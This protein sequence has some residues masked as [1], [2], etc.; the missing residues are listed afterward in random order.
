MTMGTE[1]QFEAVVRLWLKQ[2]PGAVV[3][4]TIQENMETVLSMKER[5][6]DDRI[7]VKCVPKA[8]ARHQQSL[9]L[10]SVKTKFF[11]VADDR[12]H[13]SP[14]SL[15]RVLAPF[16]NPSIGGVTTS[17]DVR[18]GT[19]KNHTTWEIFGRLNLQRRNVQHSALTYFHDGQVLNLSGRFSAYRTC[20]FD[21]DRFHE[22]L[23]SERWAAKHRITTGDDNFF[24][25]WILQRG[26]KTWFENPQN[27]KLMASVCPNHL[28]LWQLLRWSRD[29]LRYYLID[30]QFSFGHR[31]RRHVIRSLLNMFTYFVTDISMCLEVGYLCFLS[32]VAVNWRRWPKEALIR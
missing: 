13:W 25:T 18:P 22:A 7:V 27:A 26:W 24:T 5:V 17:Q 12:S 6:K 31:G 1:P 21:D 19:G 10:R 2:N 23:L 15:E 4:V 11:V 28:Y 32:F 3:I 8:S 14:Q 29:T 16:D 30:I 9:G 20:I